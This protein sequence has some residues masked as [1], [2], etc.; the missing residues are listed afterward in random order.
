V[1]RGV[2]VSASELSV[3]SVSER[4]AHVRRRIAAA[5][6][7]PDHVRILAVTKGFDVDA[8]R[9]A[10]AA[11]LVAVGE[12]Y[13]QELVAKA[14]ELRDDQSPPVPPVEWHFIGRLQSNKVRQLAPH[15]RCWQS[16]DRSSLLDEVAK[17]APGATVFIQINLSGEPTKG[18]AAVE[19]VSAL[20]HHGRDLG[21]DVGGL[22]G[23][24]PAGPAES[25]RPGFRALV[26]LADDL[27]LAE[28]SIGM[29]ADL[30]VAVHEGA[31]MV[32]VGRDLFGPR[33][34]RH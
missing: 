3:A 31:T 16:I 20:V 27:G 17:R 18:G 22:M 25:A 9:V 34:Q 19:D 30:E 11:G 21:L 14:I 12:N 10:S 32:R 28:R 23:V 5:G 26:A 7:D 6:G 15:V 13:A 29:S 8:V 4:L 33:P 24:G 1:D 2:D